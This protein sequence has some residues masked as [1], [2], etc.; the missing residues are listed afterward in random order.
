MRRTTRSTRSGRRAVTDPAIS[1]ISGART[2][3]GRRAGPRP[4]MLIRLKVR[5]RDRLSSPSTPWSARG[6]P[7]GAS[8]GEPAG[9]WPPGPSVLCVDIG[10]TVSTRRRRRRPSAGRKGTAMAGK[11][12]LDPHLLDNEALERELRYLYATRE[13]TF[14]H[15]TRQALLNHTERMLQLERE[16]ANRFPERTKADALRTRKGS[17]TEAGQQVTAGGVDDPQVVDV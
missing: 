13:E 11:F 4:G 1:E 5:P 6:G 17:R 3:G 10:A 14:F 12:G 16:Y 8:T 15:G 2:T 7:R 9:Q